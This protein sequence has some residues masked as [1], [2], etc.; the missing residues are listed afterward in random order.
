M[1][2]TDFRLTAVRTFGS[3][4]YVYDIEAIR[5]RFDLLIDLLGGRFGISYAVKANPN[6]GLLKAIRDKVVT[7]DASALAEVERAMAT[8]IGAERITFSGPGKR[9]VEIERAVG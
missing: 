1:S 2:A 6:T 4:L 7:F 9:R 5:K 3:P 8:G